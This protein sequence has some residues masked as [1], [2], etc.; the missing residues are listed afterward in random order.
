[1]HLPSNELIE[2][3]AFCDHHSGLNRCK[4]DTLTETAYL[5][6]FQEIKKRLS[7]LDFM[8]RHRET[9][10]SFTRN[11]CLTFIILITF[12]LNMLKRS[13]Q[14]ELDEF[15]KLLSGAEVAKRS[16]TKSSFTQARKKLKYGAFVELNQLQIAY[17]YKSLRPRTWMG[18]RLAAVDGSTLQVPNTTE[19]LTHFG[20]W[21]PAKGGPCPMARISQMFDVLNDVTLDAVIVP[22]AFGERDLAAEHFDHLD[23]GDLVLLDRGYPAFWLFALILSKNAHFCARMKISGWNIVK[24][25]IST[26]L[27]EQI[28]VLQPNYIASRECNQ[29]K[30][31]TQ[32][33]TIR[34]IRVELDDGEIEVLA[35]SLLDNQVYPLSIFKELY[36]LRWP[37]E[38][39]YK[40]FKLRIEIENFSGTSVLAVYQDFHAKV[41][42]ANLTAILAKPAQEIVA[43]DSSEKKYAY[44][45][46]MTNAISKMKDTIVLFFHRANILPLL[47]SIWQIMI[48]TIEPIRPGRSYPRIVRVKPHKFPVCYKATR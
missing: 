28:V 30:I 7:S 8:I 46:N 19:N 32:P 29:R 6:L 1:L 39:Q 44:Q 10:K 26:G 48:K 38:E 25:F 22:K 27:A 20:A 15:F 13:Q 47:Q 21:R 23:C 16:V 41:F 33:M 18:W 14:D 37:V 17:F 12:M 2:L 45:V 9:D 40:V 5:G 31:S 11:R 36:H 3:H 24:D 34:L 42:T 4:M 35:T 43:Q